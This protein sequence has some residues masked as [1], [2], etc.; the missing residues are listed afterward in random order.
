MH[1]LFIACTTALLLAGCQSQP[2]APSDVP[3]G[4]VLISGR[5][6]LSE[7]L[8]ELEKNHYGP[9]L[10]IISVDGEPPSVRA[11]GFI[12]LPARTP[13]MLGVS[14]VYRHADGSP[15]PATM[16]NTDFAVT[17]TTFENPGVR[18]YLHAH[19][20]ARHVVGCEPTLSRSVYPTYDTD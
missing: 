5:H 2:P 3:P 16:E 14:C 20:Q 10:K 13:L 15:I 11:D 8:E 1:R 9:C 12:E 7:Y 4:S 18:W 17:A 19:T 6:C